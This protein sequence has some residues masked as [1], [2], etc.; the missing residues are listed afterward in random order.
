MLVAALFLD[1]VLG[2][3]FYIKHCQESRETNQQCN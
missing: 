3:K 1:T 2:F